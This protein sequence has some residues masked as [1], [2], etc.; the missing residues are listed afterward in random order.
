[1]HAAPPAVEQG[2]SPLKGFLLLSCRH[3]E[4]DDRGGVYAQ[5]QLPTWPQRSAKALAGFARQYWAVASSTFIQKVG[6]H[7]VLFSA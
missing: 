1:M 5:F 6:L 3:L 2:C 4:V 7:S